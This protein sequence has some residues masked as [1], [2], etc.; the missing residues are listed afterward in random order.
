M[1]NFKKQNQAFSNM[2][3]IEIAALKF[4]FI[5]NRFESQK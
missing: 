5:T 4:N 1:L 3:L 2:A